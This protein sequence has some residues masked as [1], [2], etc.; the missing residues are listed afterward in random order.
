MSSRGTTH[1][2]NHRY[3]SP[4]SVATVPPDTALPFPTNYEHLIMDAFHDIKTVYIFK[5][6]R[7]LGLGECPPVRAFT[8]PT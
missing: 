8:L 7:E 3:R 1:V 5:P 6:G 4:S 2:G